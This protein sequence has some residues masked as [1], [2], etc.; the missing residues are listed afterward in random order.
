MT[1]DDGVLPLDGGNVPDDQ[2]LK[3]RLAS[4]YR[5]IPPSDERMVARCV[6]MVLER[7]TAEHAIPTRSKVASRRFYLIGASA[8]AAALLATVTIRNRTPAGEPAQNGDAARTS[9]IATTTPIAGGIQFDL[10]LPKGSAANVSVVG[11]FN[12]WD[13]KATPMVKDAKSGEWSAKIVLLPGRHIYAYV[14]NG[15]KWI[16]DPLKPQIPDAGYGQ[17]NAVV[18]EDASK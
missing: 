11:D 16:V 15:E 14:V 5:N 7:V 6:R 2:A 4:A 13:A 10:R 17:A 8:V 1:N 9:P 12:G 18:V 3:A